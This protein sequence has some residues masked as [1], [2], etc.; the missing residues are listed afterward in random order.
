MLN[1]VD[2]ERTFYDASRPFRANAMRGTLHSGVLVQDI[3]ST[4][5]QYF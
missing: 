1:T 4:N 5:R 3:R 2:T